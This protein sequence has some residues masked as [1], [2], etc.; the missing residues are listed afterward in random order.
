MKKK[1]QKQRIGGIVPM[2]DANIVP[3]IDAQKAHKKTMAYFK[4]QMTKSNK[5]R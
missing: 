3:M 5:K 1:K 4:N 2:A